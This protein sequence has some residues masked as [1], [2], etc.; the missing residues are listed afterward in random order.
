M[1]L[2]WANITLWELLHRCGSSSSIPIGAPPDPE[3]DPGCRTP[4]FYLLPLSQGPP[5]LTTVCRQRHK[6]PTL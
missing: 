5:R 4:K 1:V 2:V 6:P 3:R